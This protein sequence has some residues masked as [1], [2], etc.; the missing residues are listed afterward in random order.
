MIRNNPEPTNELLKIGIPCPDCRDQTE[1]TLAW[2]QQHHEL[3]CSN[4][5]SIINL[6]DEGPKSLIE[7]AA[8]M[9]R[10]ADIL[11][12]KGH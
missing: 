4:C 9:A 10:I 8:E 3:T 5:G 2:L 6:R 1:Q 12:K 11:D 7:G